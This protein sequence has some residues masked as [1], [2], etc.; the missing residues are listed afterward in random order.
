MPLS[1]DELALRWAQASEEE[2]CEKRRKHAEAQRRYRAK[3]AEKEKSEIKSEEIDWKRALDRK[4]QKKRR[5]NMTKEE[6]DIV[7]AKDRE[8]KAKDREKK[9]NV[10]S[11]KKVKV[12]K[13]T[14]IDLYA[15]EKKKLKQKKNNCTV[16]KKIR[17]SRTRT[18]EDKEKHNANLADRLRTKRSLMTT[19][20]K[21]LARIKA[22]EGMK[23]CR[24]FGYLRQYK[25][26]KIRDEYD[27]SRY[28][29]IGVN[30][31]GFSSLSY[32]YNKRQRKFIRKY[33]KN[34]RKTPKISKIE[35]YKMIKESSK[36]TD[37]KEK[38]KKKKN[39]IRV[40]RHRDKVKKQLQEP[41]ILEENSEK[42][43]YEL[44]R[45]KNIREF[46]RLKKES[47]LFD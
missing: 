12:I 11:D 14:S 17:N 43:P 10:E 39:R 38:L 20:G 26:R 29:A 6:K 24:K 41:V 25:Q 27:A 28:A 1:K 44:L 16:D 22:N 2:K 35:Y 3:K 5:M 42:G 8:R 19:E 13:S 15:L 36:E 23:L 4:K 21:D 46:D 34:Q 9:K 40:K 45:E 18:D 37:K 33:R 30:R 32:N 47:G 31:Y 7:R